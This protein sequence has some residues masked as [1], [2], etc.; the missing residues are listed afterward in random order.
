M[1]ADSLRRFPDDHE[2]LGVGI[3]ERPKQDGVDDRE[4]GGV[5]ADAEGER[6]DGDGSEAGVFEEHAG[7]VT[8]VMQQGI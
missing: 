8:E 1:Y 3:R 4:D 6:Y 7:A 5:G 2:L